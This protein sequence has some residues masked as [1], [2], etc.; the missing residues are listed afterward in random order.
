MERA[1]SAPETMKAS[2]YFRND[3]VKVVERPIPEIERN[4]VLVRVV[5]CGICGSDTMQW[6]REPGTREKG[7]INTG[8]EIA[9]EIVRVGE[10]VTEYKPGDRVVVAHHFPCM[11]CVPCHDGNETACEAMHDKHIEPGGFS[12]YIRIFESGVTRGLFRIPDNISFEQASFTELLG[13]V[14]RSIRKV[15]PIEQRC[16]LVLGAGLSGLMHIRLARALG[17][18]KVCAVDPNQHRLEAAARSG[19][20]ELISV[21]QTL[22]RVDRVFV[23]TMSPKAAEAALDAVDRGGQILYFATDGP[24]HKLCFNLTK[25]WTMQPSIRFSYGATPDDMIKAMELISSGKVRV[26]DL[27]T[28][29]FG[30]DRIGE[31]FLLAANPTNG[32]LKIIIEPQFVSPTN[33][34]CSPQ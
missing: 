26:D 33:N 4:E 15:Q 25:F 6:Y 14:V 17:A 23:C 27:V 9:G 34:V 20:D 5:A 29:R 32:S 18:K 8:H 30:I 22:P 7:G 21:G 28:H 31:A 24:D 11:Q 3:D 12:Q 10:C 1:M 19:A 2:L 13:C 16:V